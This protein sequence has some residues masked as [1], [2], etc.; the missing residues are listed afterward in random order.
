MATS[1]LSKTE[2]INPNTGGKLQIDTNTYQLF[3]KAIYHVLKVK[4]GRSFADL[5]KGVTQCFK[6][7][8]TPFSKSISWYTI[9]VKNDMEAKSVI[10]VYAQKGKKL[11]RLKK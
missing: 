1:S 8:K 9:V 3:S 7:N 5:V 2:C 10:E 4:P 6:E 11:N